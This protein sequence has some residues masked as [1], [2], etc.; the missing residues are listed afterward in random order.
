M[1]RN[2]NAKAATAD[3]KTSFSDDEPKTN[4]ILTV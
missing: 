3:Q 1:K 2:I 4:N